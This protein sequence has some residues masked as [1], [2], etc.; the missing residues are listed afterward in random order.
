[1]QLNIKDRLKAYGRLKEVKQLHTRQ[2]LMPCSR[3]EMSHE[4]R[5]NVTVI[6]N[7]P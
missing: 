1:M 6:P 5:K 2:A 3:N 4:K 7:V